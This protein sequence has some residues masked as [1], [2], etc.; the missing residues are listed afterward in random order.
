MLQCAPMRRLQLYE[1]KFFW[2]NC[3]RCCGGRD[4]TRG[5][6]CE[7]CKKAVVFALTPSSGPGSFNDDEFYDASYWI[8][9]ECESCGH[10]VDVEE[11]ERLAEGEQDLQDMI[12]SCRL[13]ISDGDMPTNQ[14]IKTLEAFAL[15]RFEQHSLADELWALLV[16]IYE[17]LEDF[18]V[19][20][21]ELLARRVRFADA[22]MPTGNAVVAWAL[23]A[24]ADA[25]QNSLGEHCA[26]R[27]RK[28]D[29]AT[30]RKCLLREASDAYQRAHAMLEKLLGEG[31]EHVVELEEK[32]FELEALRDAD[33]QVQEAQGGERE[34]QDAAETA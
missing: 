26:K 28:E 24:Y 15:A 10:G 29:A 32:F 25:L 33:A 7:G 30:G 21:C 9:A 5:L 22:V 3:S 20:R 34:L 12:K 13:A 11:A 6:R 2:C 17:Q 4:L 31:H 19:H 27:P 1:S 23:E 8:G 16:K 18:N 14:E